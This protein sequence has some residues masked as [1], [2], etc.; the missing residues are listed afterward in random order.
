M[1]GL[2]GTAFDA[3]RFVEEHGVVMATARGPVPSL[4]EAIAGGPIKGSWWGHAK[5]KAIFA[6]LESLDERDVKFFKL[7]D[8]KVTI[9]HRRVWP[10]L[11]RLADELGTELLAEI[12]QE[13]TA[14]GAHKNVI[15]PYPDWVSK[16]TRA[17]AKQLSLAEARALLSW[18]R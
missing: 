3:T 8:R 6:A 5:G 2:M 13:H 1:A 16:E 18:R 14:S 9:V 11:V 12:R 4:A 15:T 7:I 10:A 17:A